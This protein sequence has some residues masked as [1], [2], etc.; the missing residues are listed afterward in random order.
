MI[1]SN[2][3]RN[4]KYQNENLEIGLLAYE[5]K[6]RC[7]DEPLVKEMFSIFQDAVQTKIEKNKQIINQYELTK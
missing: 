1:C 6:L 7:P 3:V 4:A 2:T 5:S